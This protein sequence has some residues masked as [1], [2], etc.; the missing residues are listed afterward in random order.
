MK[1]I[2]VMLLLGLGLTA[3]GAPS[4]PAV[5]DAWIRLLPGDLPAAAYFTVVNPDAQP[6][7]LQSVETAAYGMIMMHRSVVMDGQ[8]QMLPAEN[9][10]VPA[11][12][13]LVFAPGG[14]HVMLMNPVR[15]LQVG[16]TLPLTLVFSNGLKLTSEFK[17][18]GADAQGP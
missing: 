3:C 6:L 7:Q 11:H 18:L 12:G 17:L 4:Q 10:T 8:S 2:L 9:V 5:K 14:Y 1:N 16:G 15:P 13:N